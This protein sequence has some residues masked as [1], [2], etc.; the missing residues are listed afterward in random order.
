VRVSGSLKG[1]IESNGDIRKDGSIIGSASGV[2]KE[3]AAAIYF[4]GFFD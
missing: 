1:K 3:Y 4:F 2:R